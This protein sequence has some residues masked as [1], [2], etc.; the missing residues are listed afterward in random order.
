MLELTYT[1]QR[2][3]SLNLKL[4]QKEFD[5][6]ASYVTKSGA[7]TKS[8]FVRSALNHYFQFIDSSEN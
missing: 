1:S 8:D 2:K 6:L 5:S 3:H 7:T 4:T